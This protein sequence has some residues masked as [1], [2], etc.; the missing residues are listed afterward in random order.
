MADQLTKD[1]I[2]AIQALAISVDKLTEEISSN[3]TRLTDILNSD[4]TDMLRELNGSIQELTKTF[5]D[6]R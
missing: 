5:D 1:L 3:N 6:K 2:S 4:N